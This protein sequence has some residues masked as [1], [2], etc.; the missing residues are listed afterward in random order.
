MFQLGEK[1]VGRMIDS[2]LGIFILQQNSMRSRGYEGAYLADQ[3][4]RV[5]R[6]HEMIDDHIEERRP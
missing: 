5:E 4:S 2:D 3:E 1:S 6:Y